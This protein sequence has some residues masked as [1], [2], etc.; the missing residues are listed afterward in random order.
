VERIREELA[1]CAIKQLRSELEEIDEIRE[2]VP[3]GSGSWSRRA[4]RR[5]WIG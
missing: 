5:S 2:L 3:A 4:G 1:F